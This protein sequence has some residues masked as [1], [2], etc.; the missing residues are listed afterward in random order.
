M[1]IIVKSIDSRGFFEGRHSS[2]AA[3]VGLRFSDSSLDRPESDDFFRGRLFFA[4]G[5]AT[6]CRP[7]KTIYRFFSAV[8]ICGI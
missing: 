5:R 6:E 4:M 3:L 8:R 2:V 7:Y 1:T